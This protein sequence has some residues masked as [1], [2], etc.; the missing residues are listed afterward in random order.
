MGLTRILS[1]CIHGC[2]EK[3]DSLYRPG[4]ANAWQC[5]IV[6]SPNIID[7]LL[8]P[9]KWNLFSLK[10]DCL[11]HGRKRGCTQICISIPREK[12]PYETNPWVLAPN[13][14]SLYYHNLVP[15]AVSVQGKHPINLYTLALESSWCRSNRTASRCNDAANPVDH[16]FQDTSPTGS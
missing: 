13:T 5:L 9:A 4:H 14:P 7:K 12:T 2:G 3:S 15:T 10:W 16:I 1:N 8:S 11:D 6:G